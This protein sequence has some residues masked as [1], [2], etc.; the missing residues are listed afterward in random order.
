MPP[1]FL[2][3]LIL[4]LVFDFLNGFHDS[5]NI[6]ATVIA[7]RSLHPRVAL[8]LAAASEFAGP[9]LFGV[10]IAT[11]VGDE[12]L[13]IEI[14]SLQVVI[15][16]LVAGV[17]WNL[18]TWYLGI[19]SSSSHAL[20]GG[21]LG[22]GVVSGGLAIVRVSG[23]AKILLALLIS[24]IAGLLVGFL[25]MR[26]TLWSMRRA[27]PSINQVFRR[28]QVA[29]LIGLGL[30]HGTNDA[31][32]TMGVIAMG[33]VAAGM[34]D[35]FAVPTWVIALSAGSIALGTSL[36]GWRLIRTLGARMFR[37]RPVHG[38]T[39]QLSG[40]A[41]ILGAA[42][43]GGPVSTTQVMSS[44][45]LGSGAGERINKVRWGI[46]RDMAAAWALTIP[47]TAGLAA[48]AYLLLVRLAPA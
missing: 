34:Q 12:L 5:S 9:F 30:S 48:L 14:I 13:R 22:A 37:I 11:T 42:L 36:G 32:K 15:A 4:A 46:L 18:V 24:P 3:L 20:L 35:R 10:A 38:F 17:L 39:S 29:T 27:T 16:A 31:Q 21:L 40:A 7:S 25:L 2:A 47:I 1:L 19:P 23:L 6:V 33:L 44:A 45:I 41:V 26:L 43:L 28:V 8:L